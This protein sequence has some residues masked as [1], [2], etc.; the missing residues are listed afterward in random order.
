MTWG[1]AV[2]FDFDQNRVFNKPKKPVTQSGVE[3]RPEEP[4]FKISL[5]VILRL[6][7]Q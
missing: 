6:R 2:C 1:I 5:S 7:Y 3:G 4:I